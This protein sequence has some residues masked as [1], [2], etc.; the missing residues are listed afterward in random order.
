MATT[1]QS[2]R[3]Y[4]GPSLFSFGFRPF[5]LFSA[6]WAA[7]AVPVWVASM[8][9][10]DGTVGGMDGRLWHIHEMLFGYLAGVIAGF[11]LTAVPNWTG[12]LP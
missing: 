3:R 8:T 12:R 11:L 9:L 5:F 10:G 6:A 7:L 1:A 4:S 2:I